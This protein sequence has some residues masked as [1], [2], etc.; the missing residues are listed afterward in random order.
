MS[1]WTTP[2]AAT[3]S[4]DTRRSATPADG[5]PTATPT[6]RIRYPPP[7]ADDTGD[8]LTVTRALR[9]ASSLPSDATPD[10]HADAVGLVYVSDDEPGITRH[11]WG[12]GFTYRFPDGTTVPRD[13]PA[14]ER[15]DALVIPPAWT[16]VWVCLDDHGHV[17]ATGRDDAG[18]KQYLY[19]PHWRGIRDATKFHRMG[20]FADA[21]PRIRD[22]VDAALRTRRFTREKMLA[23]VLAL[24]DE[25]QG[26]QRPVR[27]HQRDLRVDHARARPRRDLG[28]P[29]PLRLHG[30]VGP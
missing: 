15:A 3:G 12:Q 5:R 21:L 1:S 29:H 10:D 25:N 7:M 6:R 26:R 22:E 18:R 8:A 19:H 24:L 30:Q 23:L 13:H 4:A 2:R 14:R 17:Q 27:P 28:Q 11:R 9:V 16:D 20:A